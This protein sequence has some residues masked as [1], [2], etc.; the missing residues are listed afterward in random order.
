MKLDSRRVAAFLA[1]VLLSV[2][3]GFAYDGI[4]TA[5]EKHRYPRPTAY[6]AP[7]S[8]AAEEAGLPEAVIYSVIHLVS[9]FDGGGKN[10][11]GG[12]GLFRLTYGRL[13]TIYETL[14]LEPAPDEG[15]LYDPAT[16]LRAGCAYLS[17]LYRRYGTWEPVYA[18]WQIGTEQ[19][20]VW[21]VDPNRL[22]AQG[23]L[24]KIPDPATQ[25]FVNN[26]VK[27]QKL[28]TSLYYQ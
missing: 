18:A 17:E 27:G 11:A 7:I 4:A 5:V 21:I 10:E 15:M 12:V 28:Y 13:C 23:K 2:G 1:L 24:V 6:Q 19:V 3:F 26:A 8:Q 20:D 14:L 25:T 22:N 9:N 16:N